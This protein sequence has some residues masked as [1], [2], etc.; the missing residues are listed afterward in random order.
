MKNHLQNLQGFKQVCDKSLK[1]ISLFLLLIIFATNQANAQAALIAGWDF[2]TTATGGTAAAASPNSP[3]L[4][5]ANFGTGA[6]YLNGTNGSS[7]WITA[8][9]GNQVT[10]FGGTA[11]NAGSGFSTTTTSPACLAVLNSTANGKALVFSFSMTGKADLVVSYATQRTSSGFTSHQ[12]DYSTDAINW[13]PAQLLSTIPTSFAAQTLTTITGLNNASTAYLRL[14]VT[15]ATTTTGNNRLD[16]IQLV[17]SPA[18]PPVVANDTI[19]GNYGTPISHFTVASN[20]PTSYAASGLPAWMSF[21]TTTGEMSGTPNALGSSLVTIDAFNSAGSGTGSTTVIINQGTQTINFGSLNAATYGDAP[22]TLT[23]TGGSSGNPITYINSNPGVASISGNVVT[24]LGAG[25]TNI[26]ASQAG[27]ANYA[28][29]TDVSQTLL[30]NQATQTITFNALSPVLT[31][32]S[33]FNLTATGG[34]SGNPITYISSDPLVATISGNVVTIV[35][36]G[37]TDIT[38]SQA[39]DANHLAAAPVTQNLVVNN[40]SLIPQTITFNTL[41]NVTYGDSPF[42]LTATGGASGNPITY[43][44]SNPTVADV[45]G[46]VVTIFH[47]GSTTI[48]ASQAGNATYLAAV[49]VPQ[50]LTVLAKE[51]TVSGAVAQNKDYD[52]NAN[53]VITG[54]SLVG[55]VGLDVVTVSGGGAFAS[56]NAGT[57]INVTANLILGGVDSAKYS[58]VQPTGL[59]ANI[60]QATQ[61]ITFNALATKTYGDIPYT[62]SAT[63]GSSTNAVT[64]MSDNAAVATVVGNTVTIVGAGTAN[65]TASQLGDANHLAAA[66]V[67]QVLTVNKANQFITFALLPSKALGEAPYTL[68]ATTTS[69]LPILFAS[70]NSLIVSTIGNTATIVNTGNVNITASQAGDANYNP[71]TDVV[72]VQTITYPLIAAWDFFGQANIATFAATTF[73]TNLTTAGNANLITRGASAAASA[74]GNSFRTVGFQN[75]GISTANTDYFQTTLKAQAGHSLSISSINTVMAGTASYAAAPGVSSRFAYSLDG[76]NFTLL[77]TAFVTVGTP[78]ISPLIDVSNVAA[79]QNVHAS[80]TV[81]LRYYASGQTATGGWGFN[82]PIA[83]IN[84]L[85]IGGALTICTPVTNTTSMNLCS[86][87]LPYVW[88]GQTITASGTYTH[89]AVNSLGCDSSEVLNVTVINCGTTLNLNCF[90]QAYY[91]GSGMMNDALNNQGEISTATACDSITVELKDTIAPYTTVSSA[92]IIL[93]QDGTA[94]HT[95][96]GVTGSYYIVIKHRSALQTWSAAPVSFAPSSV[97]YNFTSA[98]NQAFGDNMVEVETGKWAFYSGDILVDENMD[99]LDLSILESDISN[100]SFGYLVT[101]IN[102]DGNVDLLDSPV[103]ENNISS[104]VYSIHP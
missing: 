10:S 67:T 47:P 66:D 60:N 52:G 85:G 73:N 61:T 72:R 16:N 76:T 79:L 41:S 15:G 9:S 83:G 48:T 50:N 31:T 38:A 81:T 28:A 87:S 3:S 59:N 14:T 71:A 70:S 96:T 44:S 49:P 54:A 100:F 26:T 21:N 90:I 99:L 29:A 4:F 103:L 55:I 74:G 35:G 78:A 13:T 39:G 32:A 40:A 84:G 58:L 63:G 11:I 65:I 45:V 104:F 95:F 23:A 68:S 102:G 24:I 19:Y 5:N 8:A 62:I 43:V 97:N 93:N 94:T 80:N 69:G 92:K 6:L 57:A 88:N 34:G 51:L 20:S 2:Q 53:A 30:V 91:T 101:D 77:D 75:N 1:A 98:A 82:S 56:I 46:N 22:I 42:N 25:T 27:D 86:S 17:A 33:P 37:N 64:F 18:L 7:T 12:W 36:A 89:T